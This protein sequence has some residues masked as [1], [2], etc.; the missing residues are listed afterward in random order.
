MVLHHRAGRTA[1]RGSRRRAALLLAVVA[2]LAAGCGGSAPVGAALPA[3]PPAGGPP[4]VPAPSHVVVLVMENK[5]PAEVLGDPQAPYLTGLARRAAV[6]T[7]A[8]GVAHPSQPN[9]LA[10]FAGDTFGVTDDSCPIRVDGPNLAGL[11][12][13]AGHTFAGFAEDLPSP[14]FAGCSSGGYARKHA[15]WTD[16]PAPV[17][18]VARPFSRFGPDYA[19]LP[20]V[21]FVV[22]NLCDDMHSCPVATGD[23]WVREH[24]D[25]YVSWAQT[26]DSLLIVTWDEQEGDAASNHIATLFVGPMVKPGSYGER[27]DHYGVLR[28]IEDMYRLPHAGHSEAAAPVTDVWAGPR[29]GS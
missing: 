27:I 28:T 18:S 1:A 3:G 15:P 21:S 4:A 8:H 11:L 14:G 10:L 24:L 22:P 29:A 9:Y 13:A 25:G 7:D 23:S 6:F 20:T 5:G 16:F 17:A 19:A 2:V 12:A 26:H